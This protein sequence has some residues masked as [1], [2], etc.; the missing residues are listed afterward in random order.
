MES[1]VKE[2]ASNAAEV[3]IH[4]T[5]T[6][7]PFTNVLDTAFGCKPHKPC[8]WE[9]ADWGSWTYAPDFLPTGEQLFASTALN[10][11]GGY[12]NQPTIS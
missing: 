4:L 6:A 9:L 5:V 10:N 7:E 3:G 2:L 1:Q 12:S 11:V 8:T